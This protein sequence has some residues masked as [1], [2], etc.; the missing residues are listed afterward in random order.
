MADSSNCV[1][2]D[3]ENIGFKN[4]IVTQNILR[5][6]DL[7]QR[8]E[9]AAAAKTVRQ[10]LAP[11]SGGPQLNRRSLQRGV[12]RP[13]AMRVALHGPEFIR[14]MHLHCYSA[15]ILRQVANKIASLCPSAV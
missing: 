8:A 6:A 1:V 11:T 12:T 13:A 3:L 14:Q 2:E 4:V 7:N 9:G 5:I 15:N 10:I